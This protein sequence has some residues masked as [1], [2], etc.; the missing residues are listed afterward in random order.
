MRREKKNKKGDIILRKFC[1]FV[2]VVF[3]FI[4]FEVRVIYKKGNY[5]RGWLIGYV[6]KRKK[7]QVRV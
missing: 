2:A 5:K 6:G 7:L 4:N 3:R 1:S